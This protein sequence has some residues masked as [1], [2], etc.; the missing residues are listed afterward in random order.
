[1]NFR[2]LVYIM[3]SLSPNAAN[4]PFS[5][6]FSVQEDVYQAAEL[7]AEGAPL[8][9]DNAFV[10]GVW[11]NGGSSEFVQA[12]E[13]AKGREPG[14]T[15]G[16]SLR[17][18]DFLTIVN[19]DNIH[20]DAWPLLED[21]EV[22]VGRLGA[23]AFVRAPALP[24]VLEH[25]GVPESVISHREATPIVQNWAP[26]GKSNTEVLLQHAEGLGVVFPAV[27]SLN[28][29]GQPEI[30]TEAEAIIFAR[31]THLPI[32]TDNSADKT[33]FQGSFPI[34]ELTQN[35]IALVRTRESCIGHTLM[36]R[37]LADMRLYVPNALKA[38]SGLDIAGLETLHGPELRLGLLEALGWTATNGFT[39]N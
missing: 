11:G 33:T 19:H 22:F 7:I 34:I 37:L 35:G 21:A 36:R 38:P 18:E 8:A 15:F 29:S 28:A 16:L 26:D 2:G 3:A 4:T 25:Q 12:V 39:R 31:K 30:T 1:M 20:R 9:V 23:M 14:R 24:Q 6:D 32:L 27:T 17:A 5:G 10:Y 13:A